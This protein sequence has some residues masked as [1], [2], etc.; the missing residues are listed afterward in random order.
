M[1]ILHTVSSFNYGGTHDFRRA[2]ALRSEGP[3]DGESSGQGMSRG[4][5]TGQSQRLALH[6]IDLRRAGHRY[7]RRRA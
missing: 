7:T 4:K 1:R 6:C 2:S 5:V 3:V